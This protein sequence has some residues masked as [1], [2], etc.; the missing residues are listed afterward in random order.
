MYYRLIAFGYYDRKTPPKAFR[1][2]YTTGADYGKAVM[3]AFWT[4]S[5]SVPLLF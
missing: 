3:T 2:P 5:F 4:K 1:M